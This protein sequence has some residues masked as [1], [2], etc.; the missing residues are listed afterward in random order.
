MRLENWFLWKELGLLIGGENNISI[1]STEELESIFGV[2]PMRGVP[3]TTSGGLQNAADSRFPPIDWKRAGDAANS[4]DGSKPGAK[5]KNLA[6]ADH[7]KGNT[8]FKMM[9]WDY[10]EEVKKQDGLSSME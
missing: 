1:P 8:A 2:L 7:L 4:F 10:T 3:G 5:L 6:S 9:N